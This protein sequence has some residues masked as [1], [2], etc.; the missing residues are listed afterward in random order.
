VNLLR[1]SVAAIFLFLV[2]ASLW[3]ATG[4]SISGTISD[5]SGAVVEGATLSLVNTALQT[6]YQAASDRLGLYSFPN[7]PVGHYDLT[8]TANGFGPQRGADLMV[9][10]D[11][12]LRVDAMLQMGNRADAVTVTSDKIHLLDARVRQ[13]DFQLSCLFLLAPIFSR[14]GVRPAR[15]ATSTRSLDEKYESGR[16]NLHSRLAGNISVC[17]GGF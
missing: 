2:A 7:R 11:S 9:D 13:P 6:A 8:I 17:P 16:V 4:G 12:A 1:R 14:L 5:P 3:A 10:T 15:Q